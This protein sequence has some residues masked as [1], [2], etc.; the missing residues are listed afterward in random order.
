[1]RRFGCLAV[2]FVIALL[3]V[4]FYVL[5][6]VMEWM[7][8]ILGPII[9]LIVLSVIGVKIMQFHLKRLGPSFVTGQ[10]G[11]RIIGLIGGLLVVIP[12]F[13]T[14]IIGLLMQIP[15]VQKMFSRIGMMLA[16]SIMKRALGGGFGKSFSGGFPGGGFPGG[17]LPPGGFP[18][19]KPD[20]RL[21]L[22]KPTLGKSKPK[23]YD[24]QPDKD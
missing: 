11:G 14:T 12:G 20:E 24:V 21:P 5:L 1:M 4:E 13:I 18:G 8:D 9:I 15:L 6:L 2:L 3:S 7:K 16:A 17:A 19:L 10:I 22:G 23:T